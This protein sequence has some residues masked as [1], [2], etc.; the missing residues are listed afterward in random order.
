MKLSNKTKSNHKTKYDYPHPS[1]KYFLCT[2]CNNIS[3]LPANYC[4]H[5]G[6]ELPD[7]TKKGI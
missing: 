6:I 2:N 1:K 4:P 7:S 3:K 5:C